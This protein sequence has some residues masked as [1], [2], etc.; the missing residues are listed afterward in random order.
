MPGSAINVK[1]LNF[2]HWSEEQMRVMRENGNEK[3][4]A[5]LQKNVPAYM[6]KPKPDDSYTLKDKYICAKYCGEQVAA[7]ALVSNGSASGGAAAASGVTE[8]TSVASGVV[9]LPQSAV[10]LVSTSINN[11][12]TR[13]STRSRSGSRRGSGRGS[14]S[15]SRT[16]QGWLH[17]QNAKQEWRRVWF[18]LRRD[19]L[20]YYRSKEK[21][22]RDGSVNLVLATISPVDLSTSMVP[23]FTF[24]VTTTIRTHLLA[25]QCQ[26]EMDEWITAIRASMAHFNNGTTSSAATPHPSATR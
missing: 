15:S 25:A 2:G 19:R 14:S 10:G 22:K 21:E 11:T 1:T 18:V 26:S 8:D 17:R 3:V 23:P 9:K 7:A 4:N 20:V 24:K 13:I 16:K 5:R 6:T 12:L